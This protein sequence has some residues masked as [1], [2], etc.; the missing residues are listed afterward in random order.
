VPIGPGPRD[1]AVN[2]ATNRIYVSI[3]GT[4]AA[5]AGTVAA[6]DGAS[7][8]LLATVPVGSRPGALTVNASTGRVYVVNQ[9]S[10]SL[11][12]IDGATNTVVASVSVGAAPVG[13]A[14]NP[15]TSRVLVTNAGSNDATLVDAATNAVIATL[16]LGGAG[17]VAA[18]PALGRFAIAS[19]A[20][21]FALTLLQ[22]AASAPVAPLGRP[23]G[24]SA[25]TLAASLRAL[26][27]LPVTGTVSFAPGAAGQTAVT[28]TLQG[29]SAGSQPTLVVPL[30]GGSITVPCA[31]ASG[32]APVTCS[33]TVSSQPSVGANVVVSLGGQ[34]VAQGAIVGGAGPLAPTVALGAA[35][36]Q[37]LAGVL[38]APAS[39]S[40]VNGV[41]NFTVGP[42]PSSGGVNADCLLQGLAAGQAVTLSLPGGAGAPL[43]CPAAGPGGTVTCSAPLGAAPPPGSQ[44]TA[45]ATGL[46]LA[47]GAVAPGAQPLPAP[48]RAVS[49]AVLQPAGSPPVDGI[50]NFTPSGAQTVVTVALEGLAPDQQATVQ[51]PLAG[52]PLAVVLCPAASASG[53][54]VC[55]QL[56]NGMPLPGV[57]LTVL[58]GGQVVAQGAVAAGP[59]PAPGSTAPLPGEPLLPLPP[60][61]PSLLIPP[62]SAPVLGASAPGGVPIVPEADS[63]AL[64]ALGLALVAVPALWR[65]H[66]VPR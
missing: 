20:A 40:G 8:T 9:G 57:P 5:P 14:L 32:G 59:Q 12:V 29:V 50:A 47:Q 62:S 11:S 38:L 53:Q 66:R 52:A 16:P 15:A 56:L 19:Q 54:A 28:A 37:A 60:V 10:N 23:P 34:A 55:S 42:P 27:P 1:V 65:R 33:Q 36:P 49:G 35:P 26:G 24:G 25:G 13:I 43:Q 30:A 48:V 61:P 39:G 41:C 58:T 44:V 63:V 21:P 64:V 17:A 2:A 31:P 46:P 6:L 7:G 45:S 51:V 4:A 18:N 3:T 22:D